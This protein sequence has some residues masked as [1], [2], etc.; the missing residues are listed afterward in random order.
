[1]LLVPLWQAVKVRSGCKTWKMKMLGVRSNR[2]YHLL[3]LSY[4]SETLKNRVKSVKKGHFWAN[5]PSTNPTQTPISVPNRLLIKKPIWFSD[6]SRFFG[7]DKVVSTPFERPSNFGDFCTRV[8]SKDVKVE[9]STMWKCEV[10]Q[11]AVGDFYDFGPVW[12][13][14][15]M[16]NQQDMAMQSIASC[17][18]SSF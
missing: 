18:R 10:T 8:W 11:N 13:P 5:D 2:S 16:M 7:S 3:L 17:V 9:K 6:S 15:N 14:E 12:A 1:M 4:N